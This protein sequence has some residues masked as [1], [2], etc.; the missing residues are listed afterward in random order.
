M[1]TDANQFIADLEAG[2][3]EQKLSIALSEVAQAVT[4]LAKPGEVTVKFSLKQIGDG[5]QVE[6]AHKL[7]YTRP[8]GRGK[9]TEENTTIT[10]MYVGRGGAMTLFPERQDPLFTPTIQT[11]E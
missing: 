5:S 11:T 4:H 2:I 3:F 9:A 1:S 10:P 8:T 7:S 6:V